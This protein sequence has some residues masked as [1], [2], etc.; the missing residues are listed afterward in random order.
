MKS[1]VKK[2]PSITS[3]YTIGKSVNGTSMYAMIL[4]DN[5]LVHEQGEPEFKYVGN[6]HGDEILGRELL[7]LL[8]DFLCENYGKSELVTGLIDSTRI[9]IVPTVNPDGYARAMQGLN[10][11]SNSNNIDL[12]RNFPS[13]YKTNKRSLRKRDSPNEKQ[14]A[15]QEILNFLRHEDSRAKHEIK[16]TFQEAK[17]QT[18]TMAIMQWS[19]QYPFVLSANLHS[20][21]LVVNYPFDDNQEGKIKE[22]SSP[23]DSTFKMLS[24]AYSMVFFKF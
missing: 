6:I 12:N 3:I 20:G 13:P 10:G 24:K 1:I 15:D 16:D 9:H 23:D 11:R 17:I 18:E 22:T 19:K 5:P 4:S 8:I 21:S 14:N 2:C 7:V